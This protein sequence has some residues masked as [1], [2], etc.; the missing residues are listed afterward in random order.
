[1]KLLVAVT[2][3]VALLLGAYVGYDAAG[4]GGAIF[5]GVLLG[6]GGTLL[7]SLVARTAVLVR[8]SWKVAVATTALALLAILTWGVYL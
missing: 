8:R 3:L 7:G 1:M 2:T 5:Y 4:I 6:I